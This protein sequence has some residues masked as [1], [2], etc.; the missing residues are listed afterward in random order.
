M[1][2]LPVEKPERLALVGLQ[3]G[4]GLAFGDF[5][6]PLFRDFQRGNSGF[7]QLTAT[8]DFSVGLGD[9]GATER[10]H[11]LLVSGNYF[12]ML[13]VDAAL[14]RVRPERRCGD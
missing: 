2:P 5:N 9:G 13:G 3:Y 14:G 12:Q 1:R 10:E 4:D 6:Y 7:S 8:A 11:A